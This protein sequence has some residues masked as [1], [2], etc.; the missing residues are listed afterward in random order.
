MKRTVLLL[1]LSLA[2][3][4]ASAQM[5]RLHFRGFDMKSIAPTGFRS[6]RATMDLDMNNRGKPFE[7]TDVDIVIYRAGKPYV[8]GR[9][10]GFPVEASYSVVS[11]TGDFQLCKGVSIWS[12][13]LTLMNLRAEEFTA[14]FSLTAMG[15]DGREER[16]SYTGYPMTKAMKKQKPK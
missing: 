13:L 4:P 7:I 6:L 5:S 11:A 1:L 15:D 10:P 9:C 2:F 8:T 12:V 14:D 16:F 3:L